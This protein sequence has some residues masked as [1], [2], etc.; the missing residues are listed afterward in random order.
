MNISVI[1]TAC[2]EGPDLEAT[3]ALAAAST[4]EPA[5]IIVV[6]DC[7]EV[8]IEQ[9]LMGFGSVR[10]IRPERQQG[11]APSRNF[12]AV[13]S[14]GDVLVFLDSHMRMGADWLTAVADAVT[15]YPYAVFCATCCSFERDKRLVGSGAYFGRTSI[16][17]ERKWLD[18]G[19]P[20]VVDRCPCV[21][22]AC[23]IVPRVVWRQL[24]GLN[25]NFFGWGCTEQDLSLR[26]WIMGFE[27]RRINGLVV[28]HRFHRSP[29]GPL[30]NHWEGGYNDLVLTATLFEDGIFEER[31]WPFLKQAYDP[32]ALELFEKNLPTIMDYRESVQRT[33]SYSDV[34]LHSLCE[35]RVP[36]IK[37]QQRRL[38]LLFDR[39]NR[40]R[41]AELTD[42]LSYN[43]SS[44]PQGSVSRGAPFELHGPPPK[45]ALPRGVREPHVPQPGE[46]IS[47]GCFGR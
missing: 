29:T 47:A 31:Y 19:D 37:D 40:K 24:D 4:P 32:R 26:A 15:H 1:I 42:G 2:N 20:A 43:T 46:P 22:G 38:E 12:G 30:L 13:H 5:E 33:R 39:R 45:T 7:S 17:V 28:A 6:D 23:Y 18:R 3:V 8:S 10:V 35:F 44:D 21:L 14:T 34:E 9:R 27:V 11:V 25:P 36:T 16:A 41:L